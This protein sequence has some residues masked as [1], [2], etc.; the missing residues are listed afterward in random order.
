MDCTDRGVAESDTTERLS[1]SLFFLPSEEREVFSLFLITRVHLS[2]MLTRKIHI[3]L[4]NICGLD[5]VLGTSPI[6]NVI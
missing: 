3:C 6:L 1:L 2:Y 5:T 4:L